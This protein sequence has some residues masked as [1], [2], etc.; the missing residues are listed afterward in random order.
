L[1]KILIIDNSNLAYSGSDINGKILRGTET[2][3]ILLSEAFNRKFIKVDYANNIEKET[4]YNGVRYFNKKNISKEKKKYDLAI[5]ISDACQF[6][7]V[8]ADKKVVFSV[9]IQTI[10]KFIRKKQFFAFLK[11]RPKV[12]TLCNYQ[13]EKRSLFTSLFGKIKIP[14]TVDPKFFKETINLKKIPQKK[15]IYNIRSNRN[16][17]LLLNIWEKKIFLKSNDAK[18]YITPNIINY[19]KNHKKNNIFL[20]KILSRNK[21]I[22]ELKNYRALLYPGH[23]SDIFTLTA[24]EAIKLCVPVITLGIGSLSER[25]QHNKNGFVAK[26][27]HEFAEYTNEIL[28]N[29]NFYLNIK[30]KMFKERNVNSWDSIADVWIKKIL[31]E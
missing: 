5:A 11:H 8:N 9:S 22:S 10:E 24:E 13:Y 18:L 29:D 16:L 4:I 27:E 28:N 2:S 26:N 20:R 15:V 30:K 12:V 25:V 17:D 19:T 23:K 1:K 21:M 7:N 6:E 14:I 3:L 31:N